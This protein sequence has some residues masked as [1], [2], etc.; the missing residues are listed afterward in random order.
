[1][2]KDQSFKQQIIISGVGGQG[3]LFITG[4]LS[5]AAI[6]KGL[7]V[8]TS[9]THGMAQRGG[10]VVSHLKVG[11]FPSPLIRPGRADGLL[12]LKTENIDQYRM[13]L[14]PGA[15]IVGNGTEETRPAGGLSVFKVDADL[16]ARNIRSPK[17]T[18]LILLGFALA[19]MPLLAAEQNKMFCTYEEIQ[20]VLA[21]TESIGTARRENS[22]KALEAGFSHETA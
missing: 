1:M 9:E 5:Q 16:I 13:Y 20:A 6:D 7:A 10:S 2:A 15:W 18:N 4:L 12:A 22:L 3:V 11:G 8:F 14:K 19:C 17:S 21:Q